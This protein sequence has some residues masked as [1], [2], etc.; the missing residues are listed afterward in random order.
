MSERKES[1][2]GPLAIALAVLVLLGL[3]VLYFL[4]IGPIVWLASHEYLSDNTVQWLSA[5]YWALES[6]AD[7][8][9]VFR[10]IAEWY[11][12]FWG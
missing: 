1:S 5:A 7:S 12:S 4:S 6:L 2:G 8:S 3:P 11:I 9:D 10:G